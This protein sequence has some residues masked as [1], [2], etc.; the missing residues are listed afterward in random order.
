M[1]KGYCTF[2]KRQN[3]ELSK[4][5]SRGYWLCDDCFNKKVEE[6]NQQIQIRLQEKIEEPVTK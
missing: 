1:E 6:L 2:C 3:Q 5:A 4:W